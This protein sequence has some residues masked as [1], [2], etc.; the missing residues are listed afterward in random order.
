VHGRTSIPWLGGGDPNVTKLTIPQG[1]PG[2]TGVESYFGD[3]QWNLHRGIDGVWYDGDTPIMVELLPKYEDMLNTERLYDRELLS[4][5]AKAG[6]R[7][8]WEQE[9]DS[10]AP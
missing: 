4:A 9:G 2:C 6:A 8:P 3:C 1:N 10:E 5:L 7:F